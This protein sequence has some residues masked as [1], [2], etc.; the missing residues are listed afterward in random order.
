MKLIYGTQIWYDKQRVVIEDS[1]LL[2]FWWD[3][4]VKPG[5]SK[6][7]VCLLEICW[8]KIINHKYFKFMIPLVMEVSAYHLSTPNIT[9]HNMVSS[10]PASKKD[11]EMSK[12]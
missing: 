5:K 10:L 7:L 1:L 6:F 11:N 4:A 2:T 9:A 3:D 12:A 8:R